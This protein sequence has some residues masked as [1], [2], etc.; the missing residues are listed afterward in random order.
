MAP[1]ATLE[2]EPAT[3]LVKTS[4]AVVGIQEITNVTDSCDR[5]LS[6]TL[7]T[8]AEEEQPFLL[9]RS[10]NERPHI[11]TSAS[12][13]YL[14]LSDGRK[15]L[16]ACGGAAVAILGHG[17]TEVAAAV[18]EQMSK[19][20]YVHTLSYGTNSSENLAR[21]ILEKDANGFDHGLV[22]AFFVGSGSEANDAAMK[23]ARQY[24]FEKGETKRTRFVA[25]RQAYHGNT[26]GAMSVSNMVGRKI[27]FDD[28]L[29]PNV[30]FVG[31]ADAYHRQMPDESEQDFVDR[32]I[33]EMEAEFLRL[34]PESIIS[35]IGE[36]VSGA[37]LGSMPAPKGYWPAVRTLCDKYGIL[38]H[39]DEVMCGTGRLGTYFAFEQEGDVRPD[40][41]TLGKGL[42]G[43]YAPIAG[44]LINDRIVEGLR[45]GTSAFNHGHTYQAHP[46]TCAAGLAVQKIVKREGL[47]ER[48]AKL[49]PTLEAMMKTA[50]ADAKYVG[51]IRGRGFFW[52][53]EF[54]SD[55]E[56]Q[57]SFPAS[58][59]FG[60]LVQRA[61]FEKGIAVYPGVGT[62]DGVVG[63]HVTLAPAYNATVKEMQLAVITLREANRDTNTVAVMTSAAPSASKQPPGSAEPATALDSISV[64]SPTPTPEEIARRELEA[65]RLA[66]KRA[67]DRKSQNAKRERT[68][69]RLQTLEQRLASSEESLRLLTSEKEKLEA[70]NGRLRDSL[71]A[72]TPAH[73]SSH[74]GSNGSERS[75]NLGQPGVTTGPSPAPSGGGRDHGSPSA[76]EVA[77]AE[78]PSLPN[79]TSSIFELL[80]PTTVF[81]QHAQ[82]SL[83]TALASIPG[84]AQGIQPVLP[85]HLYQVLPCNSP[86]VCLSDQI[87]DTFIKSHRA[88]TPAPPYD[89][90]YLAEQQGRE[91]P[92]VLSL[93]MPENNL[94]IPPVFRVASDV[95]RAFTDIA[96]LPE[97]VGGLYLMSRLLNW[98]VYPTQKTYR[99]VPEWLRPIPIQLRIPHP[100]WMDAIPWPRVRAV[101]VNRQDQF[102][103]DTWSAYYSSSLSVSWPYN[104]SDTIVA[105]SDE[106]IVASPIFDQHWQNLRN[107]NVTASFRNK[108]PEIALIV[109]EYRQ[110]TSV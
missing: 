34:G 12:G 74:H 104:P 86:P 1:S 59:H 36:T 84:L 103:F 99:E 82:Q 61:A 66:H 42:G 100:A 98:R 70:E 11:V 3:G 107:W 41:V 8:P 56:T 48:V 75:L 58:L 87:M 96:T 64:A 40:I 38:L 24:W 69:L 67:L 109:E 91:K 102:D 7:P 13:S 65:A 19:V 52:S 108:F 73:S 9:H 6:T 31:A 21:C 60:G 32:L 105:V 71:A 18:T 47:I 50:F 92:N 23:I 55:R 51:D 35:F 83:S 57:Q 63:D 26:F 94:N 39:L 27:P 15:I 106:E 2:P 93:I 90:E 4:E 62:V 25:R 46:V 20:S 89:V 10:L 45:Q 97:Q 54:V 78:Q 30:A 28:I 33:A 77:A 88:S 81:R 95:L 101:L 44:M 49:G 22:K 53:L 17:N 76:V 68:R 85:Q 43:G 80:S 79:Q 72:I 14:N 29:L 110:D 5:P 37:A 16:D